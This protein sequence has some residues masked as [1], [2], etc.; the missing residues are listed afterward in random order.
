MGLWVTFFPGISRILLVED[1]PNKSGEVRGEE[2][3][4]TGG[5]QVV[6]L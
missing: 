1:Y 4:S 3:L 6:R 5:M 2:L